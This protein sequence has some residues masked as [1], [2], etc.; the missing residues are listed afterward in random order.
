MG[1]AGFLQRGLRTG[2]KVHIWY[3]RLDRS[4]VFC[5]SFTV[6]RPCFLLELGYDK[7]TVHSFHQRFVFVDKQLYTVSKNQKKYYYT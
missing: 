5:R 3:P 2:V 1:A 7:F 4:F 6:S